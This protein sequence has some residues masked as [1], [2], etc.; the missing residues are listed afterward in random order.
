[1]IEEYPPVFIIL[2]K[3]VWRGRAPNLYGVRQLLDMRAVRACCE[4]QLFN[5]AIGRSAGFADHAPAGTHA[6]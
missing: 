6:A 1:M 4:R 5:V 2:G 3:P